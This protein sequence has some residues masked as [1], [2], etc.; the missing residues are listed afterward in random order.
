MCI[1]DSIKPGAAVKVRYG[2]QLVRGRVGAIDRVIDI[3]GKNDNEAPASYGL[4]DIAHVRIDVAGELEVEDYAA[5]GAIGSFLLIDQSTGD[6]L[7][8]GLVGHRLRNNWQI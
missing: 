8:A 7:A 4:K 5:R 6:T 1:R 2:T 3:D